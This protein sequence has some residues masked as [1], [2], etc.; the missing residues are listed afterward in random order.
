M[1]LRACIV[2]AASRAMTTPKAMTVSLSR[3][4]KAIGAS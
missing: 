1:W 2:P 3:E 4:L